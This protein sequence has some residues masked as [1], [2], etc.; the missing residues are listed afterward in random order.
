MFSPCEFIDFYEYSF[1]I[2][3][4]KKP[5]RFLS[6][7]TW[8]LHKAE[9]TIRM[10]NEISMPCLREESGLD[11]VNK[12]PTKSSLMEKKSPVALGV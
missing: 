12:L 11:S 2:E 3:R 1:L 5:T 4:K 8:R 10:K 7:K 6:H 9:L